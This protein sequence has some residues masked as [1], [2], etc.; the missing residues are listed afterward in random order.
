VLRTGA[1]VG[2]ATV[3]A[4]VL[5]FGV[6]ECDRARP[7][8]G[9]LG[10]DAATTPATGGM[11][12]SGSPPITDAGADAGPGA[13]PAACGDLFGQDEVRR[14]DVTIDADV[15]QQ[16]M[17]DFALGPPSNGKPSSYPLALFGSA[18]ETRT[19]ASIRLKGDKSW[20]LALEDPNPKAQ[21]V[22]AFDERGNRAAFHGQHKL[23]FDMYDHDPS[24][25]NERLAY[26][27][28]RAAG[29]PVA[30]AASAELYI[31]GANYGLYTVQETHGQ[32]YLDRLFPG[33][34]HGVLLDAGWAATV[35][36][37][38]EDM[39][40]VSALW[41]AHDPASMRAAGVDL[42]GSLRA[43][44]AEVLVND[45]DGYWAGD[46]NFF[47]Y[48]HPTRGFLWLSV[49]LDSAF[50]WVGAMQPP[51][52]WWA[53]RFWRPPAIPQHYLAVIGDPAGRAD[54][55]AA[56]AAMLD[57]YDVVQLQRWID[58]W[59]QQIAPAVARDAHLPFTVGAHQQAVSAM[60]SE[61]AMRAV[62]LR[63]FLACMQASKSSDDHDGDGYPWCNDCD[64]ARADVYPGAPELCG[65]GVDQNCDSVADEG[66]APDASTP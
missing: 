35:N 53:G 22:I 56:I 8:I 49:D 10:T 41:A 36:A 52:Y 23:G 48:D 27:F 40:R 44:A 59:S 9:P 62:Y 12:G 61:V 16:L 51:I 63:S 50:A 57:H 3:A 5:L 38:A 65:D 45:A 26:A 34:S 66:C 31:N 4:A 60:R 15:W 32:D 42:P 64:D 46:H 7:V 39:D 2:I 11:G 47:I 30:C 25:L 20:Q 1:G 29:L 33:A 14:Y 24:M 18:G 37:K 54:F 28:M 43:W 19:D 21:F 13:P 17:A 58:D 55:V 6:A